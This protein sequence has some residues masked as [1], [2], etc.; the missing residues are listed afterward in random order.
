MS[1]IHPKADLRPVH[2]EVSFVPIADKSAARGKLRVSKG[3]KSNSGPFSCNQT[4][5]WAPTPGRG[6]IF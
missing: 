3:T 4:K 6:I 5:D 2:H 1:A